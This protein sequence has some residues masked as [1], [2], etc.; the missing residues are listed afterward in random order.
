M[1]KRKEDNMESLKELMAEMEKIAVKL[2]PRQKKFVEALERDGNAT[3]A[4]IA[5]GYTEASAATQGWRL[6]RN[7]DV[8]AYRRIRAKIQVTAMG[9][10]KDTL[11]AD[12]VEIKERSMQAKPVMEWDYNIHEWKESGTWQFDAKNATKAIETIANMIGAMEP[13]KIDISGAVATPQL[14][15]EER[16]KLLKKIAGEYTENIGG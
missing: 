10:T 7:E 5:A 14:S 12:L 6:L 4:A 13:Q 2:K 11:I 3:K 8:L 1:G 16:E 15:L 9:I